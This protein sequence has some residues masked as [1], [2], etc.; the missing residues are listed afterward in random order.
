MQPHK[1]GAQ[2]GR[3][4]FLQS[5]LI[6]LTLM[7]AAGILTRVVPA[8]AFERTVEE[9]RTVVVPD[10]FRPIPRPA[11]PPWRWLTAPFEVV[12]GPDGLVVIVIILFLLLIGGAFAV[13][14][15]SLIH[16]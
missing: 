2:I 6:L 3:K 9:G 8:G 12:A 16:I 7:L 11:Y 14:D 4:A 10:S 13:L 1:A 5:L 15:L